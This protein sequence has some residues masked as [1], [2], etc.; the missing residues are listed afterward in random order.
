MKLKNTFVFSLLLLL[1]LPSFA[2][3]TSE[4]N[5]V[6]KAQEMAQKSGAMM[7][8]S[9]QLTEDQIP[10]VSEINLEFS[11]KMI[12]L[13][14]KPGS[15]F[16]KMGDAKKNSKERNT[17]LEKVLTP[18]QMKLFEDKVQDKIRKE[19]RKLMKKDS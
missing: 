15:M 5:Q 10:K 12:A 13:F 14:E 4:E 17:Q 3:E 11:K 6:K 9:L 2:Q 1:S 8:E 18:E 19:M 16:G 7:K